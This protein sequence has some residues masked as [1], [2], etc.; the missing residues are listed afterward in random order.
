MGQKFTKGATRFS[1]FRLGESVVMLISELEVCAQSRAEYFRSPDDV[2]P[3]E[4][5]HEAEMRRLQSSLA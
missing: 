2:S 1:P 5:Q 3:S 4:L